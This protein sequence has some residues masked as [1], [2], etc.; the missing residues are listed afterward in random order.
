M[1]TGH[2]KVQ[3]R[4][5]EGVLPVAGAHIMLMDMG[6]KLLYET[7]TDANG[8]TQE[9][10]LPAPDKALTLD[11]GYTQPA[12]STWIVAVEKPGFVSVRV[13]GVEVVD[14]QVAVLP[15]RME[16]IPKGIKTSETREIYIPPIGL[17]AADRK[18]VGDSE[19]AT[20]VLSDVII[21]EYITV[22]LGAPT[23]ASARNV[24]VRFIDYIKN[25]V[26]GEIYPTW[27]YS[28]IVANVHA[29]VTFAINRVYTEWYRSREHNFDITSSTAYDQSYREGGVVFEN[30]SQIVDGIFNV[31]AH[32]YGF[33]NPFFTSFCN[34]TS[35]TCA[36]LS[37]WGSVELANIGRTPLQILREYYPSDLQLS[38]CNNFSP[39]TQSYPGAPLR[40]GSTGADVRRMQ[41]YLNRI[42]AN[43]PQIPL[44]GS[45][46]GVFG[47]DTAAA[48]R[49]FQKSFSLDPDGV[50]GRATWN[51]ISYIYTAVARLAEL[52]SE[53][54]R[55][56]IG[57]TPPTKAISLG[58]KGHL[59]LELQFILNSI[60]PYYD[61]VP[62]VI[63][64]NI[65]G[66]GTKAAV[67]EFQ[68]AFG[69]TA[70]GVVG[71]ATWRKLYEVYH[72]I[73]DNIE[74]PP[75]P[76]PGG[77]EGP[78]YP[79]T[80][81]KVGSAGSDVKLMQS[82]LNVI[83][84][85]YPNI[86]PL[87][88]DGIFGPQTKAAVVAFQQQ[89]M[90]SPDGIIGPVTWDYIVRQYLLVS[91]GDDSNAL[92][93]PGE[94]LREG[95]GGNSVKLMQQRLCALHV[96]YPAIPTIDVSGMFGEE[97]RRAVQEFQRIF[98]LEPDGVIGPLTWRAIINATK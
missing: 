72:G 17:L 6:G 12:Y 30:I 54:E 63:A 75:A 53:G 76:P 46:N 87:G 98:G 40:L 24:R 60:A 52:D 90:L 48:V 51:K 97:M 29:I 15:V 14:T 42:R 41:N 1:G 55:V 68:R 50:I 47:E 32:R 10:A 25:V 16:P 7:Y 85:A 57:Q 4:A 28:A 89:F 26:S 2:L 77:G 84:A 92:E 78:S 65:F 23:N 71:P 94:P 33:R 62:T 8:D 86:P 66:P 19:T 20:R 67:I 79:G 93:Y 82:Y 83:R 58:S 11:P 31:Y 34:G 27:P 70:D 81:L 74:V 80:L 59:V 35:V 91:G 37:Q 5:G 69:L 88:V 96:S 43:F 56:D 73:Y 36:G 45:P 18:Q 44:I 39:V 13:H 38:V 3:T 61:S 22:H 49:A 21:P 64:D 95:A 9:L